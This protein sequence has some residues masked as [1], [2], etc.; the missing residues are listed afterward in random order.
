MI[1]VEQAL[2][3]ILS[4]LPARQTM[5]CPLADSLGCVLAQDIQS[6]IDSPP[7][8]KSLVD[9][10]AVVA[11]DIQAE[12]ELSVLEEIMAGQVPTQRVRSGTALQIMTGAPLPE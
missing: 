6:D 12:V 4:R 9:G 7:Y 10:Y 8:D 11:S 3:E 2:T 5:V 1:S